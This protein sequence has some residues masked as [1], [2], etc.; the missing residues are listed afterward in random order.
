MLL[1]IAFRY[2]IEKSLEIR[3]KICSIIQCD[4]PCYIF[5]SPRC[6]HAHLNAG[7]D[8]LPVRNEVTPFSP[9]QVSPK[10]PTAW[11]PRLV[12]APLGISGP[13][14]GGWQAQAGVRSPGDSCT[15]AGRRQLSALPWGRHQSTVK[16]GKNNTCM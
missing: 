2:A 13:C 3:L 10:Y 11:G 16:G 14:M 5:S 8:A 1:S 7:A 9:R 4:P 15:T 12:Q 6:L